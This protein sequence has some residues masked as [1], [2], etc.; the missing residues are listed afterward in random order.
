MDQQLGDIEVRR[1]EAASAAEL[2]AAL[3]AGAERLAATWRK[4]HYRG[5]AKRADA[6]PALLEGVV[7]PLLFEIGRQVASNKDSATD[8]WARAS[9]VLRLSLSRG[10]A[11]LDDEFELFRLV[12]E[13]FAEKMGGSLEQRRRIR[14][15]VEA[16][17]MLA[18][19]E[20]ARCEDPGRQPPEVSFGGVVVELYEPRLRH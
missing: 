7:E 3:Q 17:R 14:T 18:R 2:G 19:A 6:N 12:A 15:M 1:E 5:D 8:P 10:E 4:L 20:L 13:G 11:A 16:A 9:G